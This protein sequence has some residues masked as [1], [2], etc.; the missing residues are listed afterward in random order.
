MSN[1]PQSPAI[2]IARKH[3]SAPKEHEADKAIRQAAEEIHE[4]RWVDDT[5]RDR[6]LDNLGLAL[7]AGTDGVAL[8]R[9]P[10]LEDFRQTRELNELGRH[11]RVIEALERM[12]QEHEDAKTPE[13]ELEALWAMRE[14]NAGMAAGNKWD[15]QERWQG[16]ENERMRHGRLLTP[17]DFYDELLLKIPRLKD[18]LLLSTNVVKTH[19]D[20]KAGRVGLYI[21]NPLWK[22]E[23]PMK[24]YPQVKAR[25]LREAGEKE[26][27]KAKL[28]R[29]LGM[30][31]KADQS[32]QLAADMAET[33]TKMLM[34]H[35]TEQ[36]NNP[37]FLR[38]GTLQFPLGTEWMIMNFDEYGVPTTA[39]HLGWRTALLS[40]VRCRVITEEEAHR[41]FPV[42]SGAAG[43]WYMEQLYT[44]RNVA[45]VM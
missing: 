29:R 21:R 37:E 45:R 2:I 8:G 19:P 5:E 16:A 7:G 22:G 39:K 1:K 26:L 36:V 43:D 10:T 41:A 14:M 13:Q 17:W 23:S 24:D 18:V 31:T 34:E 12:K 30:N 11:P 38:C 32:F 20:A 35:Y 28:W 4:G 15:G 40:M 33:A 42:G 44:R 3:Q 25:E 9:K 6:V 27:K